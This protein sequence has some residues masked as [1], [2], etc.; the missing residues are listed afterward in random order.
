MS[1]NSQEIQKFILENVS[2]FPDRVIELASKEF[3]QTRQ[4]ISLHIREMVDQG[5]LVAT[6]STR[7]RK[8]KLVEP[9]S[10]S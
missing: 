6:G 2:E 9:Q 1:E 3:D 7:N 8:Y 5:L 10:D 4:A